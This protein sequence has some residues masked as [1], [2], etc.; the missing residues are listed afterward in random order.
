MKP[1]YNNW[2][3][4]SGRNVHVDSFVDAAITQCSNVLNQQ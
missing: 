4:P 3:P 2:T 1:L